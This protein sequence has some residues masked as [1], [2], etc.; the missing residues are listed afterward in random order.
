MKKKEVFWGLLCIV[1][2]VLII[3]NQFGFL[4]QISM[5]EVAVTVIL[6]GVLIKSMI[7]VNFLGILFPLALLAIIYTKAWGITIFTPWSLL[8]TALL[9]SIGLSLIFKKQ[10]Y[11]LPHFNHGHYNEHVE[12][13][14][15]N[16]VNCFVTF[17]TTIKYVNAEA[18]E[19]ADIRCSF[20]SAMV[21]FDKTIMKSSTSHID[22]DVAFGSVELYIPNTWK[23][24]NEVNTSLGAM[25]EKYRSNTP[26]SPTVIIRGE[27][28]L[29]AVE[30]V[31]V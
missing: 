15:E 16:V 8:L 4:S 14:D 19:R 5:V 31:Y 18:F 29:G 6:I 12:Q 26:D 22:V 3:A 11:W 24:I 7:H 25:E 10:M 13:D 1:A 2:A 21:Y 27:V 20:G 9:G 23:V 30:I 17:G 28:R